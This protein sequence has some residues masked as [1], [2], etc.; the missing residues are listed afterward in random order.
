MLGKIKEFLKGEE[1]EI[2]VDQ[3]GN[4]TDEELLIATAV[5]LV[6]MASADQV[7]DRQEAEAVCES[8]QG[9]FGI[10]EERIPEII[11]VAVTVRKEQGR[12]DEFVKAI[13]D[14]FNAKQKQRV[15][16]M[17]WKVVM[18]DGKIDKFEQ[19]FATQL[20]SRLQLSDEE[21]EAA[22]AMVDRGEV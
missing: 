2:H 12:I 17:I 9:Q 22:G 1:T 11:E 7:I 21:A 10:D 19:R 14:S 20:K 15:M 6:E 8:M 4:P 13:N 5:L 3:D 18:A 16:A